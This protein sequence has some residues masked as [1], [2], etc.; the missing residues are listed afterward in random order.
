M[1]RILPLFAI[2]LCNAGC[3]E[4]AFAP[5]PQRFFIAPPVRAVLQMGSAIPV[6]PWASIVNDVLPSSP[7]TDWRWVRNHPEF[8]FRLQG[9]GTWRLTARVTSVQQVLT[10]VRNQHIAFLVNGSTIGHAE[11]DHAATFDYS[12]PAGDVFGP[13]GT[14]D[15]RLDIDPCL[16]RSEAQEKPAAYCVLIHSIGLIRDQ[17]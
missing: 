2:L 13:D 14:A 6:Q 7:G 4:Q 11:I 10:A 5:P 3:G 15:I 9:R 1:H 12:F 17:P 16:I 8:Q